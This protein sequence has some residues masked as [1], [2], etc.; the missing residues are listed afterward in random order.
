MSTSKQKPSSRVASIL[1][2]PEALLEQSP[3]FAVS[4]EPAAEM[5]A[6]RAK[7]AAPGQKTSKPQAAPEQAADEAK[8]KGQGRGR[9]KKDVKPEVEKAEKIIMQVLIDREFEKRLDAYVSNPHALYKNRSDL[10]RQAVRET[11]DTLEPILAQA[12]KFYE[13]V[14]HK[15]KKGG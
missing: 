8:P 3:V 15:D 5:P 1:V 10:V 12:S 14:L 4:D 11:L 13:K 6:V 7:P 2:S 9:K